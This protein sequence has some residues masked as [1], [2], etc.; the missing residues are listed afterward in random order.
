MGKPGGRIAIFNGQLV[1]NGDSLG[2]FTIEAI[3]EDRVRY[4]HDGL[5]HEVYLPLAASFK[6]P[7]T[8]SARSPAGAQ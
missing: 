5:N 7:S 2:T 3:F 6:K 4:R 1:R 8:A